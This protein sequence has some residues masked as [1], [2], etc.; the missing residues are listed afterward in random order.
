MVFYWSRGPRAK[1]SCK[2]LS[3]TFNAAQ[4]TNH[5]VSNCERQKQSASRIATFEWKA[6]KKYPIL[7]PYYLTFLYDTIS[8]SAVL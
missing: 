3:K 2:T 8:L 4:P 5:K 6:S 7:G 1:T